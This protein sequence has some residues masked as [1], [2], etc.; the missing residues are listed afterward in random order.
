MND[1][2]MM[3]VSGEDLEIGDMIYMK[4]GKAYKVDSVEEP[5]MLV[6]I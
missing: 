2:K 5:Q 6:V 3:V 1:I 4:D